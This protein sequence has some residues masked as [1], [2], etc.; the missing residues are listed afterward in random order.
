MWWVIFII[1]IML[2]SRL[3]DI[4][5]LF[6]S[7]NPNY[8]KEKE[9]EQLQDEQERLEIVQQLRRSIGYDCQILSYD[10]VMMGFNGIKIKAKVVDLDDEWVEIETIKKRKEVKLLL[11]IK[12]ISNVSKIV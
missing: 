12:N 1:A 3:D 10:L 6:K 9:K 7:K 4:I 2:M 5:D 11:K 8:Q